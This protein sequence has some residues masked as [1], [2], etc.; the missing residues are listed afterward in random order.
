LARDRHPSGPGFQEAQKTTTI[1]A[2]FGVHPGNSGSM[3]DTGTA[4]FL[5]IW[6]AVLGAPPIAFLA[7]PGIRRAWPRA[8]GP[9]II[10]AIA[11][12]C[13]AIGLSVSRLSF[14]NVWVHVVLAAI[15]YLV[16][17][18]L[19][20]SCWQISRTAV[21]YIVG[22]VTTLPIGFGYLLG[23]IGVLGLGWIV[24]DYVSPPHHVEQMAPGLTCETTEWGT[25]LSGGYKVHLYQRW[26]AFPF[27][28]REVVIW[29]VDDASGVVKTCSDALSAYVLA[30]PATRAGT[31]GTAPKSLP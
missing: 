14:T 18:F 12:L 28:E 30:H 13:V 23:T 19:A 6:A 4:A 1:H 27:L 9:I 7:V 15:C 10:A 22:I 26:S 2:K 11:I 8:H 29:T 3:Q 5:V 25:V 17:C 21:R 24:S 16:Y 20:A 31:Y